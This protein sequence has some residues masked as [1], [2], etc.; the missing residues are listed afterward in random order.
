MKYT[1]ISKLAVALCL[2]GSFVGIRVA[3]QQEAKMAMP[4]K[5]AQGSDIEFQ[6][7]LDKAPNVVGAVQVYSVSVDGGDPVQGGAHMTIPMGRNVTATQN[8]PLG[9]RIGKWKISKVVFVSADGT[10][11][12]DLTPK[13]DL[14]FEVT[15]QPLVLPSQADID[16]R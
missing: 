6:I 1:T 3:G 8:I 5:V 13:G 12:K 4:K 10:I 16:I 11:N 2:V 9:A 15:A 7:T 14:T